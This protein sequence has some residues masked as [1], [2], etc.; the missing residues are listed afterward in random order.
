MKMYLNVVLCCSLVLVCCTRA[1]AEEPG[2]PRLLRA[3]R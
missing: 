2:R 3:E 1:N